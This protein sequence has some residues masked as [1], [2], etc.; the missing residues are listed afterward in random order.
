MER[1][2]AGRAGL[3]LHLITAHHPHCGNP[4]HG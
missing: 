1:A 2:G 3:F 4:T